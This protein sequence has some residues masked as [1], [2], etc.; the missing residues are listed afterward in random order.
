MTAAPSFWWRARPGPAALAL[1]PISKI[2]G[3]S[4]A[5]RMNKPPLFRPPV[6]V[7]CVGNFVVGGAGKTP[8]AIALARIARRQGLKPGFLAS[9][10]GG[11][12]AGPMM[13]DA[14]TDTA[15]RVGDEPLLLAAV[16]PTAIGKDRAASARI[17]LEHGVTVII[18]DDG[19]QNPTLAKDVSF[20]C[21]DA[22]A[23]IGNG[24]MI[25]SGP[26]RA[27][28]DLQLRRADALI[29]I[30][31]GDRADPLIRAAA[32]SGRPTLRAALK[33]VR[34]REW[35]K[36]PILAFAGIGRPEK[37]F[38]SL[39][40]IDAPLTETVG[41]PDHHRFDVAEA[42][43]L[44]AKADAGNLRLVTTEKDLIRL[45]GATGRLA[46]LRDRAE[47]FPI[48]LEFE[49]PVAADEMVR[50]AVLGAA[51]GSG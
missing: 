32:R 9:G 6:P 34:V 1:W 13:V 43:R 30:G 26:L 11:S 3:Q 50:D 2:W 18:M 20:A 38:A 8:T 40:D 48:V 46:D 35:R 10:Y 36:T 29:V 19:F 45:K 44:L 33:P 14:A 39:R 16:A 4:S 24:M 17:L 47:A 25:P 51:V 37:F 5:M 31:D 21:V 15:D 23:G 41:F 27:P 42:G 7:I 28:L 12:E 49:N 22:G